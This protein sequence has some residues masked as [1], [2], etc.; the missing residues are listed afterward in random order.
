MTNQRSE[1]NL[2]MKS[3]FPKGVKRQSKIGFQLSMASSEIVFYKYVKEILIYTHIY[4]DLF[5]KTQSTNLGL[6]FEIHFWEWRLTC[7]GKELFKY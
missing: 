3:S 4:E 7:F 6:T 2:L 5:S 1:V